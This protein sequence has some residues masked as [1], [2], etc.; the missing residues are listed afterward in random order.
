MGPPEDNGSLGFQLLW[1]PCVVT[2][3][4]WFV[5][6]NHFPTITFTLQ[7]MYTCS[8]S[9]RDIKYICNKH[10]RALISCF[11]GKGGLKSPSYVFLQCYFHKCLFPR[12][13]KAVSEADFHNTL[14]WGKETYMPTW[15]SYLACCRMIHLCDKTVVQNLHKNTYN[16]ISTSGI[17]TALH[18]LYKWM[19][20][21][22]GL[23]VG[24]IS[25]VHGKMEV[26]DS[27]CML[28]LL[29]MCLTIWSRIPQYMWCIY[30]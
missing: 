16:N 28:F 26:S 27:S 5:P 19:T 18:S 23:H 3:E 6:Q 24:C 15:D 21:V 25:A 9:C 14:Y 30:K 11:Q 1:P 13:I 29:L 2:P 22:H 8:T 7:C 12:W 10:I 17:W 4:A 20:K